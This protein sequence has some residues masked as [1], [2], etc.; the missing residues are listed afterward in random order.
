M[1][2]QKLRVDKIK[3]KRVLGKPVVRSH[4]NPFGGA[5]RAPD[6]AGGRRGHR[7][8]R[9]SPRQAMRCKSQEKSNHR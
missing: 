4:R 8:P 5:H 2:P 3:D 9:E 1:E 6:Q 7:R